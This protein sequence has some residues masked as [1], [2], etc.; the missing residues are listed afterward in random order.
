MPDTNVKK[1]ALVILDGWGIGQKNNTNPLYTANLPNLAQIKSFFPCLSLQAGGL[2]V[3][4]P[5]NE[6]GNSE[7]GHLTI[8]A[9]R[10][11][12]QSVAQIDTLINNGSFLKNPALLKAFEVA[13]QRGSSVCFSGLLGTG[14]THSSLKHLLTLIGMAERFGINYK[15]HL[16]TDGRDGPPKEG[17]KLLAELPEEKI[18]SISGR[19][20]AMDRDGHLDRTSLAFKAMTS[21]DGISDSPSDYFRKVYSSGTT[22]EFIRP[23]SFGKNLSINASDSII[24][25][26]FRK[27]RMKQISAMFR[28]SFPET[29]MVSF[30]EYE[31]MNGIP[32]AFNLE[33]IVNPLPK[34]LA[35][36]GLVQLRVAES[37]KKAHVTYFFNGEEEEPFPNEF[38]VIIP[39]RKV[40]HHDQF[41]EMMA[42]EITTRVTAAIEERSYGFILVNYANPDIIAHTGNFDATVKA[43]EIVDREIGL[44]ADACLRT[45]TILVITS[46][47]GNAEQLINSQTGERDTKHNA[48]PVPLIVLD[49]PF[50]R[51]RGAEEIG[52]NENAIVGSLCDIA[53]T[54]LKLMS[55]RKPAEMTG[56]DLTSYLK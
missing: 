4:L 23:A 37:E 55:I 20:Y 38:R 2:A 17:L 3:G 50:K 42:D 18:G 28:K 15:L 52:E 39:S 12:Y 21:E 49:A 35:D 6:E 11:V 5:W 33:T 1:L 24:F 14:I 22:D 8:S 32:A 19:F 10:I 41:P 45:G 29:E 53:P 48:N 31:P 56:Q 26:N 34:I 44:I 25:F 30:A 9:G 43:A 47:H 40:A 36:A 13:R 51:T 27:D 54:I 46:D 7:I 16:F